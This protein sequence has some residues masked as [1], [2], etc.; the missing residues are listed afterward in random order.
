MSFTRSVWYAKYI[1][2]L[3][4]NI[5]GGFLCLNISVENL[6]NLFRVSSSASQNDSI[7]FELKGVQLTHETP[8]S[9]DIIAK[10]VIINNNS[11]KPTSPTYKGSVPCHVGTSSDQ[12]CRAST[13]SERLNEKAKVTLNQNL[14]LE[15]DRKRET[16]LQK[17][18]ERKKNVRKNETPEQRERRLAKARELIV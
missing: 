14:N 9:S 4:L 10:S 2:F 6:T 5:S 3:C 15:K 7:P 12:K 13:S 1:W 8:W 18:R 16:K 11:Q 17:D